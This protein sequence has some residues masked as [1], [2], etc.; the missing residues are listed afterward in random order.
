MVRAYKF[1]LKIHFRDTG[2][3]RALKIGDYKWL[4]GIFAPFSNHFR[5]TTITKT[6]TLSLSLNY[7]N[8]QQE[9]T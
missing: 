7:L 2:L 1:Y 9:I 5:I 6:P 3:A 8:N 4:S